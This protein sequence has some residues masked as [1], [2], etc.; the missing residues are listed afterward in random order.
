MDSPR[1]TELLKARSERVIHQSETPV[2]LT[3]DEA[4]EVTRLLW[5]M[6]G[7][8]GAD[9]GNA[10]YEY[11]LVE[12]ARLYGATVQAAI[13]MSVRQEPRLA[14]VPEQPE[15]GEARGGPALQH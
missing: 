6:V 10:G 9:V 5:E 1:I 11:H 8:M 4:E 12:R 2:V 13:L 3:L 14:I 7:H 15:L